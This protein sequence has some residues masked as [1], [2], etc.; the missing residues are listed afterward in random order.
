ME[1]VRARVVAHRVGAADRHRP[2]RARGR[3]PRPCRGG[4]RGG[5]SGP[6]SACPATR[7]TSST[8]NSDATASPPLRRRTAPG[9]GD[10]AAALGVE[11]RPVEDEL[12]ARGRLGPQL[13][14][15]HRLE[16]LVLDRRRAGSRR[17]AP[18]RS[19][20]R[21][22]GTRSGRCGRAARCTA[23]RAR[24]SSRGPPSCPPGCASRCSA[25]ASSKPGEVRPHA[26]LGGQL[27]GQVD[28]EAV[29]VVEP[30]RDVA[31]QHRRVGAGASPPGGRPRAR[32][33]SAGSAPPR[34]G[35]CRPR[36]CG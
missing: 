14:L 10:L 36:A 25:S 1:Q 7:W 24:P 5:R 31:G 21:S 8:S 11:R 16:R 15:G 20:C 27:D 26:V 6:R 28:R 33:R 4:R 23:T 19:S 34:A 2:R 12:G 13:D 22:P 17:R 32:P 3:R 18:R 35:P 29:R 30:E 9:V